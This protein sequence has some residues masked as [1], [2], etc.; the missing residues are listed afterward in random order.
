MLK[1]NRKK[2]GRHLD[3][4]GNEKEKGIGGEGW[5]ELRG[6]GAQEG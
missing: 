6:R 3:G 5:R 2:G 4:R 1:D